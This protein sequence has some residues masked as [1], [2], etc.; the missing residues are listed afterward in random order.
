MIAEKLHPLRHERAR[1]VCECS[2]PARKADDEKP[3]AAKPI[4]RDPLVDY[5]D[6]MTR[7]SGRES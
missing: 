3:K 5:P 4:E 1:P 7:P 6:Q 2:R